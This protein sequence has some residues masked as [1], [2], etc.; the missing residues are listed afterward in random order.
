MIAISVVALALV[1]LLI[2]AVTRPRDTILDGIPAAYIFVAFAYLPMVALAGLHLLFAIGE[3]ADGLF[4]LV[5]AVPIILAM[6][7]I[8]WQPTWGSRLL[9]IAGIALYIENAVMPARGNPDAIN[10]AVPFLVP[11]ILMLVAVGIAWFVKN[12]RLGQRLS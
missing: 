5:F 1:V 8:W 6:Y 7:L 11:G 9:T 12:N 2:L 3:G 4:H 10:P